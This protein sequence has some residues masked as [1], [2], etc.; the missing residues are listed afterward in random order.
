[1]DDQSFSGTLDSLEGIRDYVARAAGEAG[2]DRGATYNLCLAVDEIV[3]N[4]I[5]HGYEEAGLSG[6]INVGADI[7]ADKLVVRIEDHGKAYDPNAHRMP[8]M[9]DL[10][11]PLEMRN[12]GGLGILLAKDA[13]DDLQY[14]S[15]EQGNT[16]RFVMLLP[17]AKPADSSDHQS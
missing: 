13:V 9:E 3:T 10:S 4:I 1:M 12:M 14:D 2:F 11:L 5:L 16:H 17:H 15:T 7:D 6:D 8:E